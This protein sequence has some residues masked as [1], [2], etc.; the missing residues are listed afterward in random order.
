L[1]RLISDV[2]TRRINN[3]ESNAMKK[4]IYLSVLGIVV[5]ELN[6][7]LGHV[8]AGIVVHIFNLQ[9]IT[10]G[11]IFGSFS[12]DIKNVLQS[13]LLLL[14]VRMISIAIPQ[15]FPITLL[16]YPLIYGIMF[17]P[18]YLIIKNQK[19]PLRDLGIDFRRLHFYLPLAL[20]IGVA[21]AA[22]E[23]RILNPAALIE[24]TQ[25]S[26]FVIIVIVMFAFVG[27]VEELIFRSILQTRLEKVIGLN[28]GLLLSSLLFGMMHSVYGQITEILFA[29]FFGIII[30]Y[31]FQKT[32][33][34]PFILAINGTSN[35]FLFGILPILIK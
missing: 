20:L 27:A 17:L 4:E 12:S 26:N 29:C 3:D 6:I 5:G 24:N 32:R 35:V 28:N 33:S 23:Y 30:G 22:L 14:L 8:P 11:L 18:I 9:I 21:F 15:F 2:L 16:W 13:M 34:F 19:I 31:I 7:L 10:I 25:I 1:R